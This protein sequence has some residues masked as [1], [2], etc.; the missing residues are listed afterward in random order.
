MVFR[1]RVESGLVE[2]KTIRTPQVAS[3]AAGFTSRE[4]SFIEGVPDA[5]SY[6]FRKRTRNPP[7][8]QSRE[9]P[10]SQGF[11]LHFTT[12]KT[13]N[14][15]KE[16]TPHGVGGVRFQIGVHD[17]KITPNQEEA[18]MPRAVPQESSTRTV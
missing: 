3:A 17:R 7:P 10:T 5:F 13:T 11:E 18:W 9:Y 14:R 8:R 16:Q 2:I 6:S 4:N 12:V 1:F 15:T